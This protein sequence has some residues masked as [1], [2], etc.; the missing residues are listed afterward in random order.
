MI[1]YEISTSTFQ[2]VCTYN[3]S[4]TYIS[5]DNKE[6]KLLW[7]EHDQDTIFSVTAKQHDWEYNITK[8][9]LVYRPV[10]LCNIICSNINYTCV[11][12]TAVGMHASIQLAMLLTMAAFLKLHK[13]TVNVPKDTQ[14]PVS[15]YWLCWSLYM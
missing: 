13:M 3:Q 14:P 10:N 15:V 1:K 9:V 12:T 8:S 6:R 5:F 11:I 2:H 7:L 4:V